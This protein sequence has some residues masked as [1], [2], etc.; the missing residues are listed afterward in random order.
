MI[1]TSYFHIRQLRLIRRSLTSKSAQALVRAFVHTRIDYCNGLLA[2]IPDHMCS[3]L[4]SVLKSSA[5][6]VLRLSSHAGVSDVMRRVLHWLPIQHRITYK[7]CILAFRCQ[8]GSAPEYLSRYCIP[9][10][11]VS[12]R[13]QLRSASNGTL[14]VPKTR[15][16]VFSSAAFSFACPSAWN[17]LPIELK[18][19]TSF[20]IFKKNLKTHLFKL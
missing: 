18:H 10:S 7:L 14:L 5:R 11:S 19:E 17:S 13:A 1:K 6:L 4:Q 2:G 3:R 8:H 16:K 9:T 12:G 15:T 20:N